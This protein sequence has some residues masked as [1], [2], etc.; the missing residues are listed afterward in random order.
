MLIESFSLSAAGSTSFLGPRSV[1]TFVE[2]REDVWS[3]ISDSGDHL[4]LNIPSPS[5]LGA[6]FKITSKGFLS[7]IRT[8][9]P[10]PA[11]LSSSFLLTRAVGP[12]SEEADSKHGSASSFVF[13]AP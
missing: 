8:H 13:A 5:R 2:L 3:R 7:L 9:A 6:F 11:F 4:L 1:G 12:V 10:S